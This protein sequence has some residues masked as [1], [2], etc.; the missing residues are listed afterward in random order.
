MKALS[1]QPE[2]APARSLGEILAEALQP[3]PAPLA[4][5]MQLERQVA[6]SFAAIAA[7]ALPLTHA[8][9]MW[10]IERMPGSMIARLRSRDGWKSLVEYLA[11]RAGLS[12][13]CRLPVMH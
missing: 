10:E 6:V 12:F 7:T 3:I 4:D 8:E 2:C 5:P 9:V 1:E 11:V 13:P